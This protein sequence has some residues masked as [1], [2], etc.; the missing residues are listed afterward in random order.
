MLSTFYSLSQKVTHTSDSLK[1]AEAFVNLTITN[2][3]FDTINPERISKI[4]AF[5]KMELESMQPEN[6]SIDIS[7]LYNFSYSLWYSAKAAHLS[8]CNKSPDRNDLLSW[9]EKFDKASNF[10]NLALRMK[11][12]M[13]SSFFEFIEFSDKSFSSQEHRVYQ[14]KYSFTPYFNQDIYPDFKRIFFTAKNSGQYHL[15]SLNHFCKI[16][17]M[18]FYLKILNE[19][20]TEILSPDNYIPTEFKLAHALELISRYLQL[21]YIAK[22]NVDKVDTLFI[23]SQYDSFVFD[24]QPESNE[25]NWN[26]DL[27]KKDDFFLTHLN[28]EACEKLYTELKDR[29]PWLPESP[30]SFQN[31][32]TLVQSQGRTI[33]KYYFPTPAPFPTDKIA[34]KN[35]KPELKTLKQ[36]DDHIKD[37]FDKAGYTGRLH[38]FYIKEPGFAVTTEIERINKNGSPVSGTN[39]WDLTGGVDES[40][41]LYNIFKSMFFTVESDYRLIACIVSTDEIQTTNQPASM[42]D[43]SALIAN[44]YS[45]LPKDLEDVELKEKTITVLLYH[46]TQNDIGKVP[47]LN[48]NKIITAH[49]HLKMTPTLTNL[50]SN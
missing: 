48:Q 31:V 40:L 46:F 29:Y 33:E 7:S 16:Y 21:D 34:I 42:A 4:L 39:R 23:Y 12:A 3:L 18:P 27:I 44:S 25:F 10:Y 1:L 47:M 26:D 22:G 38:Y 6:T 43:M 11:E 36:V 45:T 49:D 41:S 19:Y 24:L 13:Y 17:N 32:K 2:E 50:I 15:D 37:C 28:K 9:K 8:R 14:L 30:E 5:E 20:R 35:F